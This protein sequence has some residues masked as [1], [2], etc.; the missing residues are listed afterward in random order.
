[1]STLKIRCKST[2]EVEIKITGI[3]EHDFVCLSHD[4]Y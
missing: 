4:V 3:I 1:M 2:G